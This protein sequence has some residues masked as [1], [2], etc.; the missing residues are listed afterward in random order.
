MTTFL[1][2]SFTPSTPAPVPVVPVAGLCPWL[3][4]IE[5]WSGSGSGGLNLQ[6]P[7]NGSGVLVDPSG[8]TH[9]T[10]R[11][12]RRV[13]SGNMLGTTLRARWVYVNDPE[14]APIQIPV[15]R[16]FAGEDD[17]I[18]RFSPLKKLVG[19][20]SVLLNTDTPNDCLS[21]VRPDSSS[22]YATRRVVAPL[23]AEHSWDCDGYEYFIIGVE[24]R[25]TSSDYA[26][27]AYLQVKFV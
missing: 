10:R 19:D 27:E 2:P 25:L 16:V 8:I 26:H 14:A 4:V 23:N 3:T 9:S 22:S 11:L 17:T 15:I 7:V 21:S 1:V 6:D 13:A 18:A 20:V 5:P 24:R 12:F